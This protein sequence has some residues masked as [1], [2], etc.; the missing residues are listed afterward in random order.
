VNVA[1]LPEMQSNQ[2]A[3]TLTAENIVTL[4]ATIKYHLGV[5]SGKMIVTCHSI[6]MGTRK[7]RLKGEI[8]CD[9]I[10]KKQTRMN[11]SQSANLDP[12]TK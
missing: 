5:G 2:H 8:S 11:F 7:G 9:T 3:H 1:L 4:L 6:T 10:E 12:N